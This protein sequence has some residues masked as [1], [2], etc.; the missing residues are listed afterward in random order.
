MHRPFAA[1]RRSAVARGRRCV[2]PYD[3]RSALCL[4]RA[5]IAACEIRISK[6]ESAMRAPIM[7]TC[8]VTLL[9]FTGFGRLRIGSYRPQTPRVARAA[10]MRF[11]ARPRRS[12]A[13]LLLPATLLA[14]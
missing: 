1:R 11:G 2:P 13:A 6:F 8:S 12:L 9:L 4:P 3:A 14:D 7:E 10:N 5:A